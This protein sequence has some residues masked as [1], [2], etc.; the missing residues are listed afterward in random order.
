MSPAAKFEYMKTVHPRYHQ[1]SRSEKKRILDEFCKTYRCHRKHAIR[2]L[3]G[4]VPSEHRPRR[5][6]RRTYREDVLSILQSI[7]EAA[8]Y[9]W[10]ARLKALLPVWLP[11]IKKRYRLTPLQ[12]HQLLTISSAQMDRRLAHVKHR[13]RKRIYGKTKHGALLKHHIPIKTDCWD[14]KRPGFL[15]IDLVSHSGNSAS[16]DFAYTLDA[17]DIHTGWTE[18]IAILGKSQEAV[19]D[20]MN[21]LEKAFPF[22]LLGLD[23][24]NGSEF[25]ND[26]LWRWSQDRKIQF[27][28][29]RPYKKDDNAHIEQKNWTHVRKLYGYVRY[30]SPEVVAAMNDLNRHELRL[31]QN[32]FLPST[33]LIRK[34]RIGSRLTR[35]YHIP[36]MPWHR[37]LASPQRDRMKVAALLARLEILN[38]FELADTIDRK[39]AAIYRLSSTPKRFGSRPLPKMLP[40]S[41]RTPVQEPKAHGVWRTPFVPRSTLAHNLSHDRDS[42]ILKFTKLHEKE[43]FLEAG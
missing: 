7:W 24:D 16:G 3:N 15:E 40:A 32:A 2:V 26:H 19:R 4:P 33:K 39:L 5:R 37:V 20:A 29:G 6:G 31:F 41:I 17:T 21:L 30:D 35:R 27:T 10:S 22:P 11:W 1:A 25:I 13:L 12:E 38:P 23:S 18:A 8:G 36:Q 42:I 9:P 43:K 28:R 34:I 14:V